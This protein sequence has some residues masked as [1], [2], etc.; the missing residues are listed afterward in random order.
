MKNIL[1]R[2][3]VVQN[4]GWLDR[5]LRLLATAAMIAIPCYLLLSQDNAP[6]W[7][8]YMILLAV[9]P[10][11]TAVMGYDV[12]Y[13]I[14]GTKTCGNSERNPC[15][16]FPY[17]I[18]AAMGHKPIPESELEHSLAVAHHDKEHKSAA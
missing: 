16:T 5:S 13:E 3:G 12:L 7:L 6:N 18:D 9:Y 2:M 17:E 15:G 14:L 11:L 1:S 8:F 10:G 4:L